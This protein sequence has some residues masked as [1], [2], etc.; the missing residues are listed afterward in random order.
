[1]TLYTHQITLKYDKG[2]KRFNITGISKKTD[3]RSLLIAENC[4]ACAVINIKLIKKEI[5]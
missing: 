5:K 2:I 3:L 4:S 1:M